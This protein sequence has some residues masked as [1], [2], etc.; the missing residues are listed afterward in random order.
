V[1]GE[2]QRVEV[3]EADGKTVVMLKERQL[4][5]SHWLLTA[6]DDREMARSQWAEQG[7]ALLCCGG[8][9]SAMRIPAR[10]VW[11]AA[12]T[13]DLKE[14]DDFLGRFF[15]G[16]AV[17]MDLH[18]QLYYA[19]VGGNTRW[20]WKERDF[21]G[22]ERLGRDAFLGVPAVHL[23]EPRGRAYWCIP[24]ESPGALTYM[25]QVAALCYRGRT[26]A[27]GGEGPR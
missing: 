21:L 6:A 23:T 20:P 18:S 17:F 27:H 4:A 5:V 2:L 7:I 9:L 12:G 19:L 10:L 15:S 13:E 24:M 3:E 22:V 14:V 16:G 26:A 11:A 1:K 25:D 8:V